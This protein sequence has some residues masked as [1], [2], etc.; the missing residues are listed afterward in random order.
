MK[1]RDIHIRDPFVLVDRETY[2]LYGTRG[3]TCWGEADGFDCYVSHDLENWSDPV[4]IFHKP[5]G[6][7]AD[8]N[9]WAPEVHVVDG[10]YYLFATFNSVAKDRKGTMILQADKPTGPFHLH[11]EGKITPEEWNCLDGT[12]Y[13]DRQ[14]TP[15]MVFC[16]EWVDLGDG[17]IC[18]VSL[19]PDL[20]RPITKPR[21][22]FSASQATPWVRP[23]QHPSRTD[24]VYVTDGPFLFRR[25]NGQLLLLWASF[26][27]RG[28]AQAIAVSDNGDIDGNWSI[29]PTLLFEED[30]GHGMLF[31]DLRGRL[32]FTCHQPNTTGLE[33]PV[34]LDLTQ[35]LG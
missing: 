35:T 16:H 15:H 11:S 1:T 10:L 27:E 6:F 21:T 2:Y 4:E 29:E 30:G 7:S 9:Y 34:F 22:L 24:P 31:Y 18:E 5:E 3:S 8:K 20:K 32:L 17:E 12:F 23:I 28:Y 33:R 14:G 25:K 13:R 26:G 19:S